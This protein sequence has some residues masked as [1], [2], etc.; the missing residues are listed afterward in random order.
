MCGSCHRACLHERGQLG[1]KTE[2]ESSTRKNVPVAVPALWPVRKNF[3]PS[4]SIRRTDLEKSLGAAVYARSQAIIQGVAAAREPKDCIRCGLCAMTC[5]KVMNI[6]ALKMVEEGIEA[7]VDICQVCG[8]CVSVCPVN[9]L[10]VDQVTDQRRGRCSTVQRR[11]EGRKPVNIHL[12]PGGAE[13]AGD[14]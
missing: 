5:E 6:G 11:T 8:A 4:A 9:F 10:A 13:G 2:G 3:W 12:S 7:G 1:E 14:R